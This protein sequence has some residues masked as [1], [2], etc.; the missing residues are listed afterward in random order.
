MSQTSVK[1]WLVKKSE[2]ISQTSVKDWETSE[3]KRQTSAKKD[4]N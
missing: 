1:R 3:K 2:E 4:T